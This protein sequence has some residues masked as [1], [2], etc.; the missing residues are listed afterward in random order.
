MQR[1]T[2]VDE[3]ARMRWISQGD[4]AEEKQWSSKEE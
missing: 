4:E 2:Q 3:D 1:C